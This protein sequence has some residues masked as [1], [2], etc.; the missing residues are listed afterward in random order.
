MPKMAAFRPK[1]AADA[2]EMIQ[3]H[4]EIQSTGS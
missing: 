3:H 4:Y 2:D 1:T